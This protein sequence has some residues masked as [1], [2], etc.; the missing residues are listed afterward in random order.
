[1]VINGGTNNPNNSSPL[2]PSLSNQSR[3][4][5]MIPY[6]P[7]KK[8]RSV[9]MG[10][11]DQNPFNQVS[12]SGGWQVVDRPKR[13]AAIQWY[14]RSPFQLVIVGILDQSVTHSATTPFEDAVQLRSWLSAPNV[15]ASV[16]QPPTVTLKGPVLGNDLTWVVYSVSWDDAL[17]DASGELIQQNVTITL[18]EYNPPF[19]S[20]TQRSS[21]TATAAKNNGAGSTRNYTIRSGD[22]LAG[23]ASQQ[24]KGVKL[25]T[26]ESMIIDA[27]RNDPTIN[28]RSPNQILTTLVGKT[29]KIPS[30]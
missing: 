19:P 23:I 21:P 11:T 15:A 12:C 1:M 6:S 5:T 7:N 26:A 22:T 29:I 24:L 10:L 4:L 8:Y 30:A 27:N 18:Y 13:T 20:S 9:T 14:D 17:R 3:F 25:S 28:L 16:I 2:S